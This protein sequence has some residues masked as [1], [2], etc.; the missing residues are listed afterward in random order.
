VTARSR[1]PLR[2]LL[3]PAVLLAL[4]A[5]LAL[6]ITAAAGAPTELFLSEYVEGSGSN[7]ALEIFNG[8]GAP[9]SL[10]A[11]YDIQIFANGSPTATA[12]I[13]L[14]GTV[15]AG[16][17]F[18]LVRSAAVPAL[19][20]LADQ[21]TTNFLFNGNDAVALRSAGVIIDV[22]GQIGADP[23]VEWGSGDASTADNTLRRMPSIEAGDANGSDAFDTSAQWAGFPIDTFDGLGAHST[24]GGGGGGGGGG[25]AN[26]SP[27]G[28]DDTV[29]VDEDAGETLLTVL[30]NDVDPNGDTLTVTA[31][32]DPSDGAVSISSGALLYTPDVDFHGQDGFEYTVSD[33]K[34]GSDTATVA[35]TVLPVND[36]PD[37]AE[38][39]ATLEEDEPSTIDVLANDEDVDGD[40]LLVVDV[41]DPDNGTA[42]IAPDARSVIYA[43]DPDWHGTETFGYTVSDGHEGVELGEVVV[44]VTP[45]NDR[46]RAEPDSAAV[47]QDG[48]VLVDVTANDTPGPADESGQVLAIV[49]V[50]APSHGTAS[51]VSTGPDAGKVRYTPAPGFLGADTFT[52]EVSDGELAAT[53][54]VSIVVR[55]VSPRSLCGLT[56][57]LLGTRGNDVMT[58]TPGNDVIF[59]RRGNDV[60]DGGGG[61]DIVCGGPGADEITTLGGADRIAGG[62]GQ[63]TIESG[64]GADVVRGGSGSDSIAT[65]PGNDAV[66]A[67]TGADTVNTGDGS[68]MLRG[69]A[70]DDELHAGAGDDRIDGGPGAD[71]CDPGAGRNSVKNCE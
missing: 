25:G 60:I 29:S 56:P 33:G 3:V 34:G 32:T 30:A 41:E 63:D 64:A 58:G 9:V 21:T 35:L 18:V 4:F 11:A 69:G 22:I 2:R 15:A 70:G 1:L 8:T 59:G 57:T 53:G 39:T 38:D 28:N 5:A 48:S 17:A 23:G 52:Y 68:D 47:A 13:P 10:T 14:T 19:L 51:L 37:P 50:G 20:A 43:P 71:T 55:A 54:T 49:S 31:A 67:G 61:N 26:Q 12:T 36:D 24:T 16:E 7:K 42:S 40:A 62:A 45:V 65:G 66:T 44:T 27:Q 46:P 6:R